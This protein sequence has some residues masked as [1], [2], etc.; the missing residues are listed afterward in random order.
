MRR[1]SVSMRQL[2]TTGPGDNLPGL[3][4]VEETGVDPFQCPVTRKK[5][6]TE[7]TQTRERVRSRSG[8]RRREK[9]ELSTKP[10]QQHNLY[11]WHSH[12]EHQWHTVR[13]K[14]AYATGLL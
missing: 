7:T 2:G 8:V 11:I 14:D 6:R 9:E 1:T 13:H 3:A 5:Q 10:T 12:A 4:R